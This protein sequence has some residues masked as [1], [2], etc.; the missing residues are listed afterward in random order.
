MPSLQLEFRDRRRL[1]FGLY[2][3]LHPIRLSLPDTVLDCSPSENDSARSVASA[4]HERLSLDSTTGKMLVVSIER[5]ARR[6][7]QSALVHERSSWISLFLH[8]PSSL[9]LLLAPFHEPMSWTTGH[10]LDDFVIVDPSQRRYCSVLSPSSFH[11]VI[12][13]GILAEHNVN[14]RCSTTPGFTYATGL[15]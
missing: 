6:T 9:R 4:L 7:Q 2:I 13:N 3:I 5:K 15:R 12:S 1:N 8:Q 11:L 10:Q 14:A